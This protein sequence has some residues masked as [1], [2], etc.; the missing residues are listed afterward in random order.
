MVLQMRVMRMTCRRGSAEAALLAL[1]SQCSPASRQFRLSVAGQGTRSA[2]IRRCM[3]GDSWRPGDARQP[4]QPKPSPGAF[5]CS[6]AKAD[7]SASPLRSQLPPARCCKGAS[8]VA[9]WP[10]CAMLTVGR[11]N[12]LGV[13]SPPTTRLFYI[14]VQMNTAFPW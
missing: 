4:T 2:A 1:K 10:S 7:W 13:R 5:L 11:S 14:G 8:L 6:S 9:I 3:G 12:I